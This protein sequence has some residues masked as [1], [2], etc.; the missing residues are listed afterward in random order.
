MTVPPPLARLLA[1]CLLTLAC[2][3]ST[4]ARADEFDVPPVAVEAFVKD[5]QAALKQKDV[6]RLSTLVD[7]P[8]RINLGGGKFRRVSRAQ[9]AKEFDQIFSPPVVKAILEQNAADMFH[10]AQGFMFGSGAAWADAS[11]G[12]KQPW[13]PTCPVRLFVINA[14][15]DAPAVRSK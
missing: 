5:L 8:L 3:T 15:D 12:P 2:I 13:Q 11:C 9:L 6:A 14:P 4:T 10:N 7:F 1:G